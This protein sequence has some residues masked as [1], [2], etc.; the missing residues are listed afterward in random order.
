MPRPIITSLPL[1][2]PTAGEEPTLNQALVSLRMQHASI[3]AQWEDALGRGDEQEARFPWATLEKCMLEEED[4]Q[5]E[6]LRLVELIWKV[7]VHDERVGL[8]HGALGQTCESAIAI[9][10]GH[11]RR[12]GRGR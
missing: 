5:P 1:C 3:N 12:R 8:N 11:V 9:V 6:E 7:E 4:Q 10:D 2:A